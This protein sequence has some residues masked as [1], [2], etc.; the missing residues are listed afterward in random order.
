MEILALDVATKYGWAFGQAKPGI[1]PLSG[2]G[3][4]KKPEASEW[5]AYAEAIR[6]THNFLKLSKPREVVIESPV[7]VTSLMGKTNVSTTRMLFGLTA[8]IA[9]VCHCNGIY[10]IQTIA[11]PTVRKAFLGH[12]GIKSHEAK[13]KTYDRCVELGWISGDDKPDFDRADALALWAYRC[14][15]VNPECRETMWWPK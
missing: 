8:A 10:G 2:S 11:A 1:Q 15:V 7:A 4:F 9:G 14:G 5:S 6:W 3:R 13:A 12:G